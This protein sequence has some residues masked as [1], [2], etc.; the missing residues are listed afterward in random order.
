M[1]TRKD[2][3]MVKFEVKHHNE[4]PVMLWAEVLKKVFTEG[5]VKPNN[6]VEFGGDEKW[7]KIL[8]AKR[9]SM[10]L[11]PNAGEKIRIA[12]RFKEN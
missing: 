5:K 4:K 6:Y 3:R 8:S 2:F 9:I 7:W 11:K 12:T 1:S 10:F